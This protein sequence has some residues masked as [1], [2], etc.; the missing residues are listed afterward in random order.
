MNRPPSSSDAKEGFIS[1]GPGDAGQGKLFGQSFRTTV[2]RADTLDVTRYLSNASCRARTYDPLIKSQLAG[3]KN[4]AYS[5]VSSDESA[6]QGAV[7][8]DPVLSKINAAWDTLPAHIR[9][10]IAT[11]MDVGIM[12]PVGPPTERYVPD[13][14]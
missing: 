6:V 5:A 9:T 2:A 10:A 13:E 4:H 1:P 7:E 12:E 8:I 14:A 3:G 11:L